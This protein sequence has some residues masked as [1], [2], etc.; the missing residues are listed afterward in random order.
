[1]PLLYGEGQKAF[2]R[3][4][5]EIMKISDDQSLFAWGYSSDHPANLDWLEGHGSYGPFAKSPAAFKE[6]LCPM[7]SNFL[8]WRI[9]SPIKVSRYNSTPSQN[10]HH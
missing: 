8:V 7:N 9:P 6:I 1:M 5:E 10:Y 4:Q 2:V 3:L